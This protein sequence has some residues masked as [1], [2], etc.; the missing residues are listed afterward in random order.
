MLS[1][2]CRGLGSP[3]TVR[4][5]GNL[6]KS[7]NPNVLFLSET[8]SKAGRIEQ[9]RVKFGF[10][11]CFAVDCVGRSGGL[12]VF[13]RHNVEC[14]VFGYSQNHIDLNFMQ[15]NVA[16]WRLSCLYGFP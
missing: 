7:H 6:I 15:N 14:E 12:G 1:W 8:I 16:R 10:S 11:Q 2:N 3:R 4:V 13:W 5:L 9:L